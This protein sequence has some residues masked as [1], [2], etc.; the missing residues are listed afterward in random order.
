[1]RK[2]T[3]GMRLTLGFLFVALL[4]LTVGVIGISNMGKINN[5]ADDMYQKELLGLSHIKE[6]NI[7]L[8][9]QGRALRN[10]L[11]AQT[12]PGIEA[13][14]YLAAITKY[15]EE[16]RQ[17]MDKARGLF[18]TEEGK[19][20]LAELDTAY[21]AY[22]VAQDAAVEMAK[23]E[24]AAGLHQQ[25][26]KSATYAMTEARVLAD[27][28][29]DL[30]TSL[31]R[32]KEANA[33][34]ASDYTTELY[35]SSKWLMITV[36][37]ASV[38][39][40]ILIGFFITRNLTRQLGGEP[41]YVQDVVTRVANGDLT[42]EVQV[43]AN[44][45]TSMLV[46]IKQ[47]VD[48][49]SDIISGVRT[50]SDNLA[51]A[52]EEVAA[53]AQSLSQGS[54]EQAASVE[55][56]SA[57][58]EQMTASINQNA[59]NSRLTDG[60]ATKSSQ[61]A[62]EGGKAV[63]DTVEAMKQIADKIGLIEDIAY[64]TNLLALNAAIEAARAGEHGKGFAV[65]ADEVRKLAERSQVSAQEILELSDNSVKVAE[66]AGA[67]LQEMLPSIQKTADLVQEITAASSEQASGVAQ[68]S[69]AMEQLDKVAQSSAASSEELAAT[70]EEMS[71]QSEEL[72]TTLGFFK[73][74][75]AVVKTVSSKG[76]VA[77]SRKKATVTDLHSHF[78]SQGNAAVDIKY[79]GD[80]ESF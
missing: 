67:L 48:K 75:E 26:R 6:A 74:K 39:V 54:S 4:T 44:D 15:R 49:L 71:G 56:T 43:R 79:K 59:E 80:F 61:Q 3:V 24:E 31:S 25:D 60:M 29:D 66:R 33:K 16:A 12:I 76:G 42:V 14:P 53:T 19:S 69:T 45:S 72:Q 13:A 8:I 50:A 40:G 52:S 70:A 58:L 73:L 46:A 1:M 68:V 38:L 27:K 65:V 28:V 55:E 57:S 20:K 41:D 10:Y 17:N 63:V 2:M 77:G 47:M 62:A 22:I 7:D 34:Q 78:V 35:V 23:K 37:A 36:V 21:K 30:M 9:Y 51:S 32:V 5:A 11:L 64:K 18:F